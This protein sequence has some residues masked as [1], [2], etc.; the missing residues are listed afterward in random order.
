MRSNKPLERRT[1]NFRVDDWAVVVRDVMFALL[2]SFSAL[3]MMGS[4]PV[5]RA[6]VL[7]HYLSVADCGLSASDS[8][9]WRADRRLDR[10]AALWAHGTA[11]YEAVERSGYTAGAVSGLHVDGIN[12]P[13]SPAPSASTCGVL[14]DTSLVEFGTL[15]RRNDLWVVFASPVTLPAAGEEAQVAVRALELVNRARQS[16]QHCGTRIAPSASPLRLSAKLSEA[17]AQ[18][19]QDMAKHHYFEHEDPAG[20]TP[21]D[22]VRATGYAERRVGENIAYGLLSTEDVIAGWLKSPEHCEN[23]MDPKFEA[24]GIAFAQEQGGH[25]DIFWVQVLAAP[26]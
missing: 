16:R 20:H 18:H 8:S 2:M 6:D 26:K 7:P 10:A 15:Q 3:M 25:P 9:R 14:R 1:H 13:Q 12:A 11:L 4:A 24:M 5:A 21:A 19:A 17:A 23:L 22:R